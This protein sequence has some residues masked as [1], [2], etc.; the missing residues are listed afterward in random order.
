M[1]MTKERSSDRSRRKHYPIMVLICLVVLFG[2]VANPALSGIYVPEALTDWT[3]WVLYGQDEKRCPFHYNDADTRICVW[4]S[5]LNVVI[6]TASGRF[7]LEVLVNCDTWI[8]IPGSRDV[9]PR[10]VKH[11][12]NAVPVQMRNGVPSV[13]LPPGQSRI[14]GEFFWKEAP[15][16]LLIPPQTGVVSLS[17]H[18]KPIQQPGIDSSG[19][20]WIYTREPVLAR[21]NRMDIRIFR[22]ITDSIP[23]VVTHRFQMDISGQSREIHLNNVLLKESIPLSLTSPLPAR[24]GP[25][26]RVI[27]QARSGRWTLEIVTRFDGPVDEITAGD[28]AYG[29]EIWSFESRN[30]LR[31]VTVVGA[32][33]VDPGQTDAPPEWKE[34]PAYVVQPDTTLRFQPIRRGDADPAPDQLNLFRTWWLDFD[35]NGFTIQDKLTG[36]ISRKWALTLNPPAGLGK[37]T[38]DGIDQL[39]T[40][41]GPDGRPGVELRKGQLVMEADSRLNGALRKIPAVGWDS[42]FQHVSGRLNLPPGWKLF[43][44]SGV[45]VLPGTWINRWTLLDIFVVLIISLSLVRL[46]SPRWGLLSL[47]TLALIYHQPDA[48]QLVWLNLLAASALLRVLP[49]GWIRRVVVFWGVA[50]GVVLLVMAIPFMIAEVREGLYPQL[51]R[52]ETL[53]PTQQMVQPLVKEAEMAD[54]MTGSVSSGA[55]RLMSAPSPQK[56][57]KTDSAIGR[58]RNTYSGP[59]MQDPNALIQTGPGLPTWKWRS[60]PLQWNG[61]VNPDQ[62]IR[63][64]LLSPAMNLFLGLIRVILTALLIF[65]VVDFRKWSIHLLPRSIPAAAMLIFMMAGIFPIS[66][67]LCSRNPMADQNPAAYPSS[68]LLNELRNRLLARPDCLP[69][70]ADIPHM[71]MTVTPTGLS[72]VLDIHAEIETAVPLPTGRPDWL[73]QTI[74]LNQAPAPGLS[75]DS[76]GMLWALIPRGI[77]RLAMTGNLSTDQVQITLP[78]KPRQVDTSAAGWVIQGIQPDGRVSAGIQLNRITQPDVTG[79]PIETRVLPPFF[80]VE[81]I[82]RLALIWEIQTTITRISPTG[83]PLTL[84]VPLIPAELMTTAG[85]HVENGY[86]AISMDPQE[87][88]IVLNSRIDPVETLHLTSPRSVPWTETWILEASPIWHCDLSGIPLIHHQDPDGVWRP[89]WHPWPGETVEI[90]VSRPRAIPGPIVTIDS[91]TLMWTPGDRLDR[92]D[93]TI[94]IRTS[95]GGPH[96]ALIPQNADLQKV[97]I[98]DRIQPIRQQDRQVVIPLAPGLQKVVLEWQMPTAG[99]F[100][101]QPPSVSPGDQAVNASVTIAMP[102]HRW[103]LWTSGPRLGPAVLFW[104]Y[105]VVVLIFAIGLGKTRLAPL[106]TRHWILLC[107]GLTQIH[108]LIAIVI[109]GWLLV[110]GVRDRHPPGGKWFSFNLI[111]LILSGW[112]LAAMSGLYMAVKN[113][114]LGIPDMQIMGNGSTSQVL[115]WTEDRIGK[116]MPE[117]LVISLPDWVFHGLML[118]WS[119]W[120]A[121]ALLGWLKWGWE[122]ISRGGLWKPV[123]FNWRRKASGASPQ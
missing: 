74:L 96:P 53:H 37:A 40:A 112:T 49:D 104:G 2:P 55:R 119:L 6:D 107:V 27:L 1:N 122:C 48:P 80:Q 43:A 118:I 50:S 24:I 58:Y 98:Q 18:G 94:N 70:C 17:V 67:A 59:L 44:A 115:K 97:S 87:S 72:I 5:R 60:H 113:G 33:A 105:L 15:E 73:P 10:N 21:E 12:G 41:Q 78:I 4:P 121:F 95:R 31:M 106:K 54:K 64:I 86:A 111:Q 62:E 66:E 116:L 65:G 57:E 76:N 82:I 69:F 71:N 26:N 19:R 109:V 7:E 88:R 114:L 13:R 99:R 35:G 101:Y 75:T 47:V 39:I 36:T 84:R 9:Y 28:G 91:A 51:G 46:R 120:L 83:V 92:A 89:E 90:R 81:R 23:M 56:A 30:H 63:L 22:R 79:K 34:L 68:E 108:P 14:T 93:L 100:R 123:H 32:P 117:P 3:S 45:D 20:L 8:S 61:P 25:D 102:A 38:V 77:H 85:I 11:N 103:I 110:L 52:P 42:T 29:P 16:T